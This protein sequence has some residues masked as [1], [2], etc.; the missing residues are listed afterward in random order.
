MSRHTPN[1]SY[2]YAPTVIPL[3]RYTSVL[4]GCG[5]WYMLI[6]DMSPV[7]G[8]CR[9]WY[10]HLQHYTTTKLICST[11]Q[12]QNSSGAL[13]NYTT[14]LE[15]YTTTHLIWSTTQLIWSARLKYSS[16]VL[17]S[18][19]SMLHQYL[20]RTR[21]KT[22]KTIN[23]IYLEEAVAESYCS[24][25]VSYHC[26]YHHN[27]RNCSRLWNCHSAFARQ[28]FCLVC[29]CGVTHLLEEGGC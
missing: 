25:H 22:R 26:S 28:L 16:G 1:V 5:V 18:T 13:H 11:T 29:L 2:T 24:Y 15:H 17:V 6:H 21:H 20:H 10:T 27:P 7:F 8:T 14:H 19:T 4:N 12:L 9:V 3:P 23:R